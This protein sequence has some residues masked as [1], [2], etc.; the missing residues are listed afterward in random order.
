LPVLKSSP[1]VQL[2]VKKTSYTIKLAFNSSSRH[3]GFDDCFTTEVIVSAPEPK[4]YFNMDQEV[5][6]EKVK[7]K[8]TEY[9]V[10]WLK[11]MFKLRR[12]KKCLM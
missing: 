10:G 2:S 7:G 1:L 5:T 6:Y 4:E 12:Y 9:R 8:L 11:N 3:Q